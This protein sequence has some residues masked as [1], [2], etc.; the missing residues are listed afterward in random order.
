M[1]QFRQFNY[2]FS[3]GVWALAP[4]KITAVLVTIFLII[5]FAMQMSQIVL[6][7]LTIIDQGRARSISGS[8]SLRLRLTH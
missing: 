6:Q 7:S 3:V 4:V 2:S 1:K 5:Y 8:W